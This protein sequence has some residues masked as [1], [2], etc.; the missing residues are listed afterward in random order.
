MPAEPRLAELA[1]RIRLAM[2][3]DGGALPFSRFM[4]LSLYE[5]E[6][7]YYEH[8]RVGR[9]G[10]FYTSV[11]VGPLF[12]ELMALQGA[13]WFDGLE[14]AGADIGRPLHWVEAGAHEG[15]FAADFLGWLRRHRPDRYERIRYTIVE[16]SRRRR[17]W[18]RATLEKFGDRVEWR[19]ALPVFEGVFFGNELLDAFPIERFGWERA[20]G[21]WFRWGVHPRGA[22]F[23][24]CRMP[25]GPL[26]GTPLD[27]LPA[28]LLGVLPDGFTVECSPAAEA[29]WRSAASRLRRGWMVT[30]D[31]GYEDSDRFRPERERGTLRGYREHRHVDD[32]LEQPGSIDLTAHVDFGRIA[33]V[34]EEAGLVTEGLESQ[35]R[36]LTG[37]MAATLKPG[38]TFGEWTAGR[39][40]QFQTL[41]HPQH[42][43]HSFRV[44]VQKRN[45]AFFWV[46]TA[47]P[48]R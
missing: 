14:A 20:S 19:E 40:R 18:Q 35:R 43:G 17:E 11:S 26:G 38:A 7:G 3:Q 23:E 2:A 25:A 10:D 37:L 4:E 13:L 45:A 21:S 39:V 5:P 29:W 27:G 42:L 1:D 22:A 8:A 24:W 33:A 46:Q 16:P 6:L 34:G 32:V 36:F 48:E 15:R 47:H 28:E 44:L 9:A 30:F 31:Y 41:T 12:G